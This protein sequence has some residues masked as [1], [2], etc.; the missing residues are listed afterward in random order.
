MWASLYGHLAIITDLIKAGADVNDRD[1]G[2]NTSLIWA[3]DGYNKNAVE[4]VRTL[5]NS[6]ADLSV[7]GRDNLTALLSAAKNGCSG[8]LQCLIESVYKLDGKDRTT[9]LIYAAG[10]CGVEAIKSLIDIGAG[11]NDKDEKGRTALL[12]AAQFGKVET[13]QF[14]IKIGVNLA[15][16]DNSGNTALHL[17]TERGHLAIIKVLLDKGAELDSRALVVAA[18]AGHCKLLKF[19]IERGPNLGSKDSEGQNALL[20]AIEHGQTQV[21]KMLLENGV[22]V[23]ATLEMSGKSEIAALLRAATGLSTKRK[24]P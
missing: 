21:V 9:A 3:C 8:V 6:G 16:A 12:A 15:V 20:T 2:G 18:K 14:L 1:Y 10:H 19:L 24:R 7:R 5:I 23:E 22:S 4:T 11:V 17:A 13:V